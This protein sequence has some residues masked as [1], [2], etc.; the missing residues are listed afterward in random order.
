RMN[1]FRRKHTLRWTGTQ[2]R[3]E[4]DR[5]C[6]AVPYWY[7]SFHFDNGFAVRGC[8]DIG[9]DLAGYG[10]PDVKGKRVLDVGT[11]NGWFAF[12]FEQQGAD[13]TAVDLRCDGD[14]DAFGQFTYTPPSA[15]AT[16]FAEDGSPLHWRPAIE[17]FWVIHDLL[18]SRVRFRNV[19]AA[20]LDPEKLGEF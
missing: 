14:L 12:Y 11:A 7:H 1:W 15:P 13:V 10:F 9:R 3:E 5:R 2:S 20:E 17:G 4:F 18:S 16:R 19:R 6:A 8:Y